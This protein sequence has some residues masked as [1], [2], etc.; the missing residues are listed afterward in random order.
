MIKYNINISYLLYDCDTT[1]I[2]ISGFNVCRVMLP[3]IPA[4][5]AGF[6]SPAAD[7]IDLTI[8]LGKELVPHPA[9]TFMGRVRGTSMVDA[10]IDDQDIL[11]IDRSLPVADGKIAVCFLDGEFTV[12]RIRIEKGQVWLVPENPKFR[13]IRVTEENEFSI[14]G[15]VTTIIKAV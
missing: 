9:T 14:W 12:K 15:I 5:S 8:D 11:I 10:G 4:L 1:M 3:F 6:P 7:F 13:P 2:H